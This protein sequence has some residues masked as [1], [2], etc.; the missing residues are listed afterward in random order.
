MCIFQVMDTAAATHWAVARHSALLVG[1]CSGMQ[2][3]GEHHHTS[4][5]AYLQ[6]LLSHVFC[7]VLSNLRHLQDSTGI[8]S[9]QIDGILHARYQIQLPYYLRGA[10]ITGKRSKTKTSCLGFQ[11]GRRGDGS[12]GALARD[13]L[14]A[15]LALRRG[16]RANI[17]TCHNES[18]MSLESCKRPQLARADTTCSAAC[19]A[20][21]AMLAKAGTWLLY[22]RPHVRVARASQSK[23]NPHEVVHCH[24]H[25]SS[26]FQ[27]RQPQVA[28]VVMLLMLLM[29][30]ASTLPG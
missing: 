8:W 25:N 7:Q 30:T 28:A 4:C 10:D 14:A 19:W 2:V 13:A 12:K 3:I 22:R 16:L 26:S 11:L 5:L 24:L 27:R 15:D 18:T 17:S 21:D 6:T 1:D 23:P 29:C 9:P 20:L